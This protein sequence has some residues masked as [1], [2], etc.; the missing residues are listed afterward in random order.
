MNKREERMLQL[1]KAGVDTS[2]YFTVKVNEDIPKG[3]TIK[4]LFIQMMKSGMK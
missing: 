2:K 1:E 3:S 4:K